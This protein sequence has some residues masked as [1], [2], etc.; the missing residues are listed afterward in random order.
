[1]TGFGERLRLAVADRGALCVGIDPHEGLLREWGLDATAAGTRELGLR[2]VDAAAGRVAVVKPQVAFFERFGS[3]GFAALEDVLAAARAAGLIAIADAK[4]GDIGTTMDGYAAAWLSPG[5][6]LEADAVTVSPYLGVG[7]LVPTFDLAERHGFMLAVPEVAAPGKGWT[8]HPSIF[9][10]HPPA[11]DIGFFRYLI[12][13]LKAEYPV[14]PSRIYLVGQLSGGMMAYRL[15]AEM[16]GQIAAIGVVN[17]S[18]GVTATSSNIT[19]RIPRPANPVPVVAFHGWANDV[20]PYDG[21]EGTRG[22]R[23]YFSVNDSMDFWRE[24]NGCNAEPQV[25]RFGKRSTVAIRYPA[26][27]GFSD[28]VLYKLP[29]ADHEW[30]EAILIGVRRVTPAEIMWQFF[31]EK[32]R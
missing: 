17:A 5:A 4:R 9:G 22:A 19:S 30:P 16:S 3:A 23:S 11:D 18:I 7:A 13:K 10:K 6:P 32:R 12:S 21:G 25:Q 8:S 31:T 24:V 14:D 28:V 2:V 1:M 29:R 26:D 20:L 15:A 27:D